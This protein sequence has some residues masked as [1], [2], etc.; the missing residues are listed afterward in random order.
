M[1]AVE[2]MVRE[3]ITNSY[4]NAR[5]NGQTMEAAADRARDSVMEI[6]EM[7]RDASTTYGRLLGEQVVLVAVTGDPEPTMTALIRWRDE[8]ERKIKEAKE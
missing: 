6:V 1:R 3:A 5:N 8:T 2:N 7:V 4:Y